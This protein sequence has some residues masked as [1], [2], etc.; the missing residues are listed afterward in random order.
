M[1]F[2]IKA[3]DVSHLSCPLVWQCRRL[4]PRNYLRSGTGHLSEQPGSLG[5]GSLCLLLRRRMSAGRT[6][7]GRSSSRVRA[8]GS[9]RRSGGCLSRGRDLGA[10]GRG[11]S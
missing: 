4:V 2:S 3:L 10:A 8:C 6:M 1:M 11:G 5:R 9:G 7:S